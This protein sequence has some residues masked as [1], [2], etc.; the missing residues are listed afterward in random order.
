MTG[1]EFFT[2]TTKTLSLIELLSFYGLALK[3]ENSEICTTYIFYR[4]NGNKNKF[5]KVLGM[6]ISEI[7]HRSKTYAEIESVIRQ[8]IAT[9]CKEAR[10]VQH[11]IYKITY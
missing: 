1:T 6:D 9:H 10:E 2:P 5:L 11:G 3:A 8:Y 7:I 4:K